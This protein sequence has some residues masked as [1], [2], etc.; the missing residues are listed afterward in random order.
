M[1]Y[2]CTMRCA[3]VCTL[4]TDE[5]MCYILLSPLQNAEHG[6]IKI[7]YFVYF[8]QMKC[9]FFHFISHCT[10][11]TKSVCITNSSCQHISTA[12]DSNYFHL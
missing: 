12:V 7:T 11:Y 5:S 10:L 4:Y 3:I 6:I 1:Y 9:L 8:L 2:V